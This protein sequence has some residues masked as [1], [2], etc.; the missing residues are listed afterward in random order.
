M[1]ETLDVAKAQEVNVDS[2]II[3]QHLAYL[4]SLK[5][6]STS[7]MQR[8]LE[9]GKRLE[10]HSLNGSVVRLGRRFGIKTPVNDVIYVALKQHGAVQKAQEI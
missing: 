6:D 5:P 8:D 2:D 1:T 9:A 4:D 10:V 3:E 7:S